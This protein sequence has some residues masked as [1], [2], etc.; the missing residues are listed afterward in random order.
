MSRQ[1]VA[2]ASEVAPGSCKIVVARGREIGLFNIDGE[3]FALS[4]RCPHKGAELC[5]GM[6]VG[7]AQSS[8]PGEYR[9]SRPGEFI[10]C[11]WH[12][13]EFDIRTGQSWCDPKSVR[14]R[15]FQVRVESGSQLLKGPYL[16]ETF[17]VSLEENYLVIDL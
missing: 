17:Q 7:L 13:W 2:H 4:N 8:L 10:R 1:V 14:A 6:I 11:P 5:R 12:G 3:F 9:L 15:Q 16:A